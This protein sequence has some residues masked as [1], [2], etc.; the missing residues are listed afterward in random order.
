MVVE[1]PKDA[2]SSWQINELL[3]EGRL[4]VNPEAKTSRIGTPYLTLTINNNRRWYRCVFYEKP[5]ELV[6][7]QNL[8]KGDVIRINGR[9]ETYSTP[10]TCGEKVPRLVIVG[11]RCYLI[12]RSRRNASRDERLVALGNQ[13]L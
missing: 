6:R 9:I 8:R 3:I 7:R 5:M 1:R 4:G 10:H 13:V 12:S 2:D 11:E